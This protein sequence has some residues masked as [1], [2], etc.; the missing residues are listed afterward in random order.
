MYIYSD[1]KVKHRTS[2][3]SDKYVGSDEQTS[4][5]LKRLLE[6]IPAVRTDGT[7]ITSKSSSVRW[8]VGYPNF[9]RII[10][11]IKDWLYNDPNLPVELI[12]ERKKGATGN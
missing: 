10:T 2:F 6:F 1:P 4:N 5:Y 9:L 7:D 11:S 12:A 3:D 8:S